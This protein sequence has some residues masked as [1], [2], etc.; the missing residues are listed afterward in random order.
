MASVAISAVTAL[1]T[2]G[3][4][5]SGVTAASG[6]TITITAPAGVPLDLSKLLI[7]IRVSAGS[8]AG[9]YIGAG[10]GYSSVGQGAYP[11]ITVST[12]QSAYYIGGKDFES[13]RFL[14]SSAQNIIITQS[15]A[16][17]VNVEAVQL[18]A[19]FTA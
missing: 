10:S 17:A 9:L 12:T 2:G 6:D 4:T 5:D 18:P 15:A 13:A 1:I 16:C 7:R 11:V 8:A 3:G 19:G 14:N